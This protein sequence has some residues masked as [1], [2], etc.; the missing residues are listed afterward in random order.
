LDAQSL[1]GEGYMTAISD[2]WTPEAAVAINLCKVWAQAVKAEI[3]CN[4]YLFGSAIYQ[5]GD[6]FDAQLSDLDMIVVFH[7]DMDATQ[8]VERLEKLRGFKTSLELQ[9]VPT[10]HRSNCEEPGVSVIPITLLELQANVHKS[11][12]RRFFDKNIFFDLEAEQL[13]VSLPDAGIGTVPEEIRQALEYA[14]KIRNQFLAVSANQTGSISP[15]DGI[16]PIPKS[17]ARV[18]AQLVLEAEEGEWYDTR[19]GLEYLWTELSRRRPDS[20]RLQALYRKISVRRGGRGRRQPL[21][22]LDQLLLAE[23]LYDLAARTPLQP[24][25]TWE[26]RFIGAAP[27]LIEF[28][29]LL[30]D[31]RRLVPDGHVL[32]IF[33]GSIVIRLRSSKRSY[34]TIQ[35]LHDLSAVPKFFGVDAVQI[36]SPGVS[37]EVPGFEQQGPI[38]RITARIA[39]WRPRSADSL[40]VT[41]RKLANWLDDWLRTDEILDSYTL[42]REALVSD[43]GSSFNADFLLRF[44]T[45]EKAARL[46][47]ELI[48]LRNRSSFFHQLEHVL[49]LTLPTIL[50]VVGNHQQLEGL[51]GDIERLAELNAQIHV[52][53]VQLDNG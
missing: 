44:G 13:S 33:S 48:R 47:I 2:E 41:E 40:R 36:S 21:T 50:V 12:A 23:I 16:D 24:L 9:L 39:E 3:Q 42:T 1:L 31:L 43:G 38:D 14:Q 30:D 11:G 10:L 17:L 34:F 22:D 19:L 4:V 6:Q 28:G 26:I 25:T 18:A 7:E 53:T 52:V 35:R 49:H 15:F 37:R 45:G 32:G 8:R 51:R 29:R 5:G 27:S 46:V 20:G